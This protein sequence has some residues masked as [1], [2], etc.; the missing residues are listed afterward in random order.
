MKT[1]VAIIGAGPSGLLLC[2]LLRL[3]GID[4]VVLECRDREYVEGRIRAGVLEQGT[5]KLLRE[6]RV[7]DRMDRE[8]I[9]HH[10]F[11][12]SFAG[13]QERVDLSGHMSH[14]PENLISDYQKPTSF[15]ILAS[16]ANVEIRTGQT[17][18]RKKQSRRDGQHSSQN[19]TGFCD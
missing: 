15:L 8:G 4:T 9:I 19:A 6:A 2:R 3:Q 18:N 14:R 5:V 10:G 7:N 12:V 1:Q 16:N 13:R 11:S 17:A